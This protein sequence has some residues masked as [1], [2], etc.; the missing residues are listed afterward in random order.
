MSEINPE[1]WVLP[2]DELLKQLKSDIAGLSNVEAANRLK[3]YGASSIK[4]KKKSSA[5]GLFLAQFKSPIIMI[6]LFAIVLSFF[7]KDPVDAAIIL[8]IVLISGTLGFWQEYGANNAVEKLLA[9]VQIKAS[10]I[11]D[12][13]SMEVS[14]DEIVPGDIVN[15][16]A[17]DAVPGD[18]RILES[19]SLFADE[20]TLTGETYPIE[21]ED[22]V[23]PAE[24]ALG[25]RKNALWMGTHIISGSAKAVVCNT[26][27]NTQFGQISARLKVAPPQTEF[28]RGI[29]EFGYLLMKITLI[30]VVA[31]FIIN[32]VLHRP[33]LD[34]FLFSLALAVGLT[35]QLL[36]AIISI[37]LAHGA[38]MMATVKVIVKRLSSI[39]N[40]GSMDVLCSD[41][42]GTLTDGIV[43][44]QSA[45]DVEGNEN[46][47]V[48]FYA[49]LN[50][51][52]ESGFINPIDEAIRTH[53]KFE[54]EGYTKI[55]EEPYDFIRKRLSILLTEP[56]TN[57]QIV[58]TKGALQNV[59]TVCT[60][61][62]TL[63]GK[64]VDL[65]KVADQIKKQYETYSNLGYRTLG[66]AYKEGVE[67]LHE[68]EHETDLIFL[69]QGSCPVTSD[70]SSIRVF[71]Y[72]SP[73]F[74][75]LYQ[76]WS[77]M[78]PQTAF[79][80]QT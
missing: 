41:K 13:V 5:I 79:E 44:L 76:S 15:F 36:P 8:V 45:F 6:L 32:I 3:Q 54:I 56:G 47:K 20:A 10:V 72:P 48:L 70:Q 78:C 49:Y 58:I 67:S 52:F 4:P 24:T 30:L 22:G 16:A 39:E 12:G 40:F 61:A 50:A 18:C 35:P 14:V 42:T 7:L 27:M 25:M 65:D 43:R 21:K 73:G 60:R 28:E 62:E 26:G 1:F 38:K 11:R 57:K 74:L 37:N 19:N 69:V 46:E 34:A 23:L 66:V 2:K 75:T 59:L 68:G 51:S 31:I 80:T 33:A 55:G 63:D 29:K 53:K 71:P 17:G 64:L 9:M 77:S